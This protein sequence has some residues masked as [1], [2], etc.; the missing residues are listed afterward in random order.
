MVHPNHVKPNL[1]RIALSFKKMEGLK[2][3]SS[4]EQ[5]KK[6]MRKSKAIRRVSTIPV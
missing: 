5:G 1:T 2:I 4:V 6:K 3:L